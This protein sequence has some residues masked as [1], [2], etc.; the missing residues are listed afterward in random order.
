MQE[1][2]A[3]LPTRAF[4][5]LLV[6]SV[7]ELIDRIEGLGIDA[8]PLAVEDAVARLRAIVQGDVVDRVQTAVG[9]VVADVRGA[10]DRLEGLL[11]DVTAALDT[12]VDAVTPVLSR[13]QQAVA[14][15]TAEL[16]AVV[17]LRDGLDLRAPR[18]AV[19]TR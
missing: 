6:Q 8:V 19:S 7:D 9:A 2:L 1:L 4:R 10:I 17:E 3:Q 13:V 14:G 18:S 15:F 16:D 11:D 12:A 5:A